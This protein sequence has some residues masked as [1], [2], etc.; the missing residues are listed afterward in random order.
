MTAGLA[1]HQESLKSIVLRGRHLDI[2][3]YE[4][5]TAEQVDRELKPAVLRLLTEARSLLS[6]ILQAC[7]RALSEA[8]AGQSSGT[9]L[10]SPT[11]AAM[12]FERAIDATLEA[13]AGSRRAV[14]EIAFIAQLELRQRFERLE[15]VVPAHGHGTMLDECDSS[16]RRSR[17]ALTAVDAAIARAERVAPQLDYTSELQQSLMVRRVY[18]KFRERALEGG[19]PTTDGLRARFRAVGTLFAKLVG[20]DIYPDMRVRD[21]LLLR[22]LQQRVLVWLRAGETAKP[23]L[24]LRL[25][26]DIA[27]CIE[28]LSLVNRR[29]ELIEH[30]HG[31]VRA[32]EEALVGQS[33]VQPLSDALRSTLKP[34]Q[35]LDL[36]LDRLLAQEVAPAVGQLRPLLAR[37]RCQLGPKPVAR[38]G[39]TSW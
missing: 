32:A 35:G 23:A 36:E 11:S 5:A 24:G 6:E 39:E 2:R 3:A 7:E 28:M 26:Q 15:R 38:P 18:S 12:P 27:A 10:D 16:L 14:E 20:E 4:L 25:W 37:L 19:E 31:R 30:D 13:R 33:D 9:G 21:R 8:E 1:Q 17:K 34:L 22:D 29:Q